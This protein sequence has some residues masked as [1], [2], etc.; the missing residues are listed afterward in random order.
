MAMQCKRRRRLAPAMGRGAA[1]AARRCAQLLRLKGA[2]ENSTNSSRDAAAGGLAVEARAAGAVCPLN[3][4]SV[5]APAAPAPGPVRPARRGRHPA[6]GAHL[7]AWPL[8]A[9]PPPWAA[10][11]GAP[12]RLRAAR[13]V[14]W[15]WLPLLFHCWEAG[16]KVSAMLRALDNTQATCTPRCRAQACPTGLQGWLGAWTTW[17]PWWVLVQAV[18]TTLLTGGGWQGRL[19]CRSRINNGCAW[20]H[21]CWPGGGREDDARHEHRG[22]AHAQQA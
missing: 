16:H 15:T 20:G 17:L 1:T 2:F 22:T 4:R 8:Q 21:G 3:Q 14:A 6:L 18:H 7:G 12:L 11:A 13:Q 9:G 19:G 5:A 10:W